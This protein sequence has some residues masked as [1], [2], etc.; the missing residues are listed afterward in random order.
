[1]LFVAIWIRVKG[2]AQGDLT[3]V[4]DPDPD[5]FQSVLKDLH[6]LI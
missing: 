2:I 6:K 3:S 5:L 4:A 1:M